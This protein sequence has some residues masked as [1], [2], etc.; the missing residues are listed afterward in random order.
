MR[1]RQVTHEP[2]LGEKFRIEEGKEIVKTLKK[3]LHENHLDLYK[4]ALAEKI[5][6]L[7]HEDMKNEN[8]KATPPEIE[9]KKIVE[10]VKSKHYIV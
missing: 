2:T 5:A 1:R 7:L 9:I 3:I 10:L 8:H 4:P 6:Y